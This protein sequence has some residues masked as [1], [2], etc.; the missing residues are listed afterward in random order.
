MKTTSGKCCVLPFVY[1]A[2]WY[3]N[4]TIDDGNELWCATTRNYDRDKEWG[5][6]TVKGR[7]VCT[8]A[9]TLIINYWKSNSFVLKK[10]CSKSPCLK[11]FARWICLNLTPRLSF[12]S[13]IALTVKVLPPSVE[14]LKRG[15]TIT[16][17]ITIIIITIIISPSK[18]SS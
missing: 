16:I 5:Y 10:G 7:Q 17:T 13:R 9:C 2:K 12:Y 8:I 14:F 1:K 3:S 4:C 11:S 18:S 6:C 15:H